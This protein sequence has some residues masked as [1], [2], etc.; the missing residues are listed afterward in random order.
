M[1]PIQASRSLRWAR[2]SEHVDV[3]A[4][5]R[6]QIENCV[7]LGLGRLLMSGDSRLNDGHALKRIRIATFSFV[8]SF[9]IY[10]AHGVGPRTRKS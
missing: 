10:A 6:H 7:R 3:A 9:C 4:G 1:R 2:G 8:D 5:E